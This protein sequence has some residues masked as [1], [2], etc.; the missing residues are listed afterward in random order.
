MNLYKIQKVRVLPKLP[1]KLAFLKELAYNLYWSWDHNSRSLFRRLD[2]DLWETVNRNPVLM[3]GQID[4]KRLEDMA[5]NQGYLAQLERIRLSVENYMKRKAWF[6]E[7]FGET[8]SI[9]IAY[10]SMEFGL[11]SAMP[12]Y[13]G[14]LGVLAGD[15]LKSASDLGLPFYGIGLAYQQGYFQQY[16]A[17]DGWQQETYPIND[18]Y[19]LPF[20]LEKD[21]KGNPLLIYVDLPGRKVFAQIW[22]VNIGRIPLFLLDA[23][24]QQNREEDR[25]ITA[26][27]YGGDIEMRIKQEILLGIG[28][29]RALALMNIK[30]EVCHMNEGHS[31]FLAIER[32]KMYMEAH[33]GVDFVQ[34]WEAT[35]V[36][37]VFTTH[38][39]VPAGID[40]FEP[41][42]IEQYLGSYCSL[43]NLPIQDFIRLGGQH[44]AQAEGKFNMAIFAINMAGAYNGVSRLH[45]RVARQMWNY[46][47]PNVP[48]DEVPIG[49]VTNG[50]HIR[51]WLSSELSEL[52]V[53]YLDPNWYRNPIE[54]SMWERIDQ[55]PDVELWRT[56]ERRRE[57]LVTTARK[58]LQERL[59]KLGA[60][61]NDIDR[62]AEVLRHDA[63]TIG[64][65]RRFATYKRAYLLF[66]DKERLREIVNNE[67]CPV[68]II[69][70]GKAHPRDREG[71]EVLK[72]I[73]N[74]IKEDDFRDK[75]VFLENYD[76]LLAGALVQ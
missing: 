23:N 4:Q 48:P 42:L 49:H 63:L 9:H 41:Y 28:G 24:I 59:I 30:P 12:V 51:S 19:N 55:I 53:R 29:M 64:F 37:N 75:I 1:E 71:K 33:S 26:Q 60:H 69:I 65:A 2:P 10:F 18:F 7:Q 15:H 17:S 16:L 5:G 11:S 74:I 40:Q 34:A 43:L 21:D 52:Y 50:I 35:R 73:M 47:W 13:S 32:I 39:P 54:E 61:P 68:Q 22:R 76:M 45:G 72:N 3:L 62:A 58:N 27:L 46:L 8:P 14:G 57:R 70:S 6:E 36:G 56:H 67:Q 38:T 66:S 31:A 44:Y 25:Q 20:N